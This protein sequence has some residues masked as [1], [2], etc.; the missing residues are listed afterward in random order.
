QAKDQNRKA[1]GQNHSYCQTCGT[2]ISESL[3]TW[4]IVLGFSTPWFSSDSKQEKYRN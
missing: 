1:E 3:H 2:G 4:H